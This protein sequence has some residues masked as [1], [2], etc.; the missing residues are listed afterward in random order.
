MLTR[1]GWLV[2]LGAVALVVAGRVLGLVEL[3]ALAGI[4]ASLLLIC[5]LS[6]RLSRL[7]LE[8]GRVVQPSRVHVGTAGR[9][10]LRLRN[11]RTLRTPV[12]RLRDPVSGTRG[13]D[14]LV[15]PLHGGE[16][17]VAAYRLPTARRGLLRV[18]PLDVVVA[19]P[20]GL[21]RLSMPA[22]PLTELVVYPH[23]DEVRPLPY[24]TGHDPQAGARRP[25]SLGR[26]GED[27]YA[28]RPYVVGDDLRKVHWPSSARHGDLMVRQNEL[29]W[30][31]RTT[32]VVDI[33]RAAVPPE[34]LDV[35]VSAAAS[36]INA[37]AGRRDLVRLLT[38][39]GTDSDFG[40]GSDHVEA[41]MEHLAV[42]SSSGSASLRR[43]VEVLGRRS[44]GGSLVVVLAAGPDDDLRAVA[45]LRARFG[46]VSIIQVDRSAYEP[47]VPPSE[48]SATARNLGVVR[49]TRERPFSTVWDEHVARRAARFMTPT[50]TLG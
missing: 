9:V 16:A 15:P 22:A 33:R 42:V 2:L 26:T 6:V 24:T 49:I 48:P 23:V 45:S 50:G 21:V 25:N 13:A 8:V 4:A 44:T 37:A 47:G 31:G 36:V 34:A 29:P 40:P 17:T 32:V 7:D 5:V 12:L 38:T 10:E 3:Y 27:F 28:L 11:R 18:G 41:I 20:F 19:D 35:A 43:V 14:L 1:Q 30:Q 39:D 46:W